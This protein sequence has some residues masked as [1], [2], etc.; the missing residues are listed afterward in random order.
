[1]ETRIAWLKDHQS[2]RYFRSGIWTFW[3]TYQIRTNLPHFCVHSQWTIKIDVKIATVTR[4]NDF[5]Q[6]CKINKFTMHLPV[7]PNWALDCHIYFHVKFPF[8]LHILLQSYFT[9]YGFFL[10]ILL[11]DTNLIYFIK[12]SK[13]IFI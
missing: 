10:L 1:M 13:S 4:S 2:C 8:P 12:I 5:L 3:T 7:S 6:Q 9:L 11:A